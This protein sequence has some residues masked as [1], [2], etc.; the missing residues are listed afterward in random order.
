MVKLNNIQIKNTTNTIK[1]KMIG[2]SLI[3]V[4]P[5]YFSPFNYYVCKR[6]GKIY[7]KRKTT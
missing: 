7:V 6:C 2:H 5:F 1:C 4:Q 3:N